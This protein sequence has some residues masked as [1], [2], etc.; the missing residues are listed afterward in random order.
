VRV[1]LFKHIHQIV[2]HSKGGYDF[3][4]VYNLPI[5][6]RK[7]IYNEI[8]THYDEESKAYDKIKDGK[9]KQTLV[10]SD[11]KINTPE[12]TKASKQYKQVENTSNKFKGKTSF[13]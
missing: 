4:T 1:N 13:K 5:W 12:F 6:L 3:G 7:F 8:K 11:G 9:G 10:N 2:F